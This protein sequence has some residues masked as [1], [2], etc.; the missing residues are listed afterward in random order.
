M[1][2]LLSNKLLLVILIL[3]IFIFAAHSHVPVIIVIG[4]V[5]GIIVYDFFFNKICDCPYSG[6]GSDCS[7]KLVCIF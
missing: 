3:N 5:S 4:N 7:C 6:G 2:K 1:K